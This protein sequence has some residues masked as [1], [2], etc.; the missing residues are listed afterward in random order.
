LKDRYDVTLV[1]NCPSGL[2]AAIQAK[3]FDIV[4]LDM[5]MPGTD[6]LEILSKILQV[7]PTMP[8]V[9]VTSITE[10]KPAVHAMKMG[11][12]DY[13]N[14]PFDVDEVRLVVDRALK[15]KAH[16]REVGRLRTELHALSKF[17]TT[18][19]SE[20][21]RF[22]NPL[23]SKAGDIVSG[24]GS[25]SANGRWNLAGAMKLSYTSL[26]PETALAEA[27]AHVRYYRLPEST[28]LPRVLVALDLK[29]GR[30]LDLRR[31]AVRRALRLSENAI[32]RGDWRHDNQT[33]AEAITQAW[34]FTF[35]QAGFEAV[36]VPS[37][38]D[39][40]GTNVLV[41]PGNLLAASHFTVKETVKWPK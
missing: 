20:L 41:Y 21:F 29:V 12:A 23:Y 9:M 31:G 33:G 30:A 36:I 25:V 15:E 37:A 22:I 13:L 14:K 11:A 28:A 8:V 35:A 16:E 7:H 5:K 1:E 10:A 6:G 32:R 4:L 17:D 38:A 34:G 27:L 40:G 39:A 24:A 19:A 26:A 2:E 3:P 18:F